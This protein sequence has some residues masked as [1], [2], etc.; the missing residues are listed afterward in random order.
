MSEEQFPPIYEKKDNLKITQYKT[1]IT[2]QDRLLFNELDYFLK[3]YNDEQKKAIIS[4]K[5]Q[6]LC[7]AGAGSGKTSALTK[8]IEF[9]VKYKE[10]EK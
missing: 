7:I 1:R 9:L 6:I 4:D 2:D 10:V 5:E 3:D 8:R